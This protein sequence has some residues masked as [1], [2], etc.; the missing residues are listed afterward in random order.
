MSALCFVDTETT[1]LRPDRRAWEIAVIARDTEGRDKEH[2]WFVDADQLDLGSADLMALKI[3]RFHD[4]HPQFRDDGAAT[5]AALD[6]ADVLEAV[7]AVTRGAHLVGAVPNFD[8]EVLGARMRAQGICP[9]WHYHLVDVEA[10]AVGWL[11]G[12]GPAKWLNAGELAAIAAPPWKSDDL[13]RAAGVD[14]DQ[15]DRH[16]ALGDARWA[17]AIWDAVC[18]GAR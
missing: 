5:I 14:P 4:R 1:S 7:E 17:R 9:S 16:T 3:G 11:N 10:L 2:T 6:E 18:G 12:R 13:S 8:A 15:F